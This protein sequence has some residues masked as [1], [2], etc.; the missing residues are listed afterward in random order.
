MKNVLMIVSITHKG[1]KAKFKVVILT[2]F[3][4]RWR[5]Y[6][7]LDIILH[8]GLGSSDRLGN[9]KWF[10]QSDDLGSGTKSWFN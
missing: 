8:S 3:L 2:I 1:I 6:T 7:I 5:I 10:E 4:Y 9:G